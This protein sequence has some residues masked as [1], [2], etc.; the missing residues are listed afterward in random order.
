MSDSTTRPL[1]GPFLP[2]LLLAL[3]IFVLLT[4]EMTVAVQQHMAGL[5]VADQQQQDFAKAATIENR[6]RQILQDLVELGER[7]PDAAIIVKRYGISFGGSAGGAPTV[8]TTAPS[9]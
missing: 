1:F 7:N 2:I 3:S 8:P 5:R 9:K 4:W 6:L